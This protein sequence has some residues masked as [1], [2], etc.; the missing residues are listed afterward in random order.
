[1]RRDEVIVNDTSTITDADL[2][3]N[4]DGIIDALSCRASIG[5]DE[6][7]AMQISLGEGSPFCSPAGRYVPNNRQGNRPVISELLSGMAVIDADRR[8]QLIDDPFPVWLRNETGTTAENQ[9][10]KT[11]SGGSCG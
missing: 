1:M 3:G 7:D 10:I 5:Y 8:E 11:P 9:V 6:R 4:V 2:Y